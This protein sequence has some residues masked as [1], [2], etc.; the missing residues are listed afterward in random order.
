[1]RRFLEDIRVKYKNNEEM[2]EE[3]E[4]AGKQ[5]VIKETLKELYTEKTGI[6]LFSSFLH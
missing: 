6:A 3:Y 5:K 4:V 1:M 2:T